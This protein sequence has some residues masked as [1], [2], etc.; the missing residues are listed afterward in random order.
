[1]TKSQRKN[2]PDVGIK[3]GATCMPSGHASDRATAPG[4]S[5]GCRCSCSVV[6]CDEWNQNSQRKMSHLMTK[7]TKWHVHPAKTQISL[8]I[9]PIWSESL[10][11][12]WCKL[13]S[14]AS[15]WAHSK[16]SDQ[17][18]RV[19][20]LIWVFAGH[21]PYCWFC[22]DAVQMRW[23]E[24]NMGCS[25]AYQGFYPYTISRKLYFTYIVNLAGGDVMNLAGVENSS[26]TGEKLWPICMH[27]GNL[28]WQF[29]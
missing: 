28:F 3:L 25:S 20:R 21:T 10:L 6:L 7:P 15:H 9:Y 2:V 23:Q 16:D 26:I 29:N 5:E 24:S 17:T 14:L 11:S 8:G 27:K 12:A 1:M 4:R 22:R 19:P 18:G 13:G